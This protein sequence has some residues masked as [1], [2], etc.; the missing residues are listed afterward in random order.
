[1][2]TVLLIKRKKTCHI[3]IHI[4]YPLC[5]LHIVGTTNE[6]DYIYIIRVAG[7]SGRI[8]I[9]WYVLYSKKN[10]YTYRYWWCSHMP[11]EVNCECYV[12]CYTKEFD[13][14]IH[15]VDTRLSSPHDNVAC[16]VSIV[17]IALT[18]YTL[19]LFSKQFTPFFLRNKR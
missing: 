11:V 6:Q 3:I 12:L 10:S 9:S 14:L 7:V 16:V 17:N 18:K 13:W 4:Y 15:L 1:M 19:I 5:F 2:F 8:M